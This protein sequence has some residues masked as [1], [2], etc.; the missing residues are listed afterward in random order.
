[1]SEV[2]TSRNSFNTALDNDSELIKTV[3]GWDEFPSE[4]V[5]PNGSS[6]N[7][8]NYSLT[9]GDALVTAGGIKISEPNNL[10]FTTPDFL[11]TEDTITFEF[12]VPVLAFGVSF[13]TFA[14]EEGDYLATNDLGE[15]VPSF[16]DPSFTGASTGA[17]VGFT[18]ED[19]FT[20]VT[21]DAVAFARYGLDDLTI[22]IAPVVGSNLPETL[23]GSPFNDRIS[24]LD[25]KDTIN[26][27]DGDDTILGGGGN[28]SLDGSFGDDSLDGANG[29]DTLLGG[30][31]NDTLLG[32]IGNDF[33]NS[34]FGDDFLEGGDGRDTLLGGEGNDV[35]DGGIDS[36]SLDG[37][38][39]DDQLLGLDGRDTLLG[40]I[41]ND[42]LD[43]GAG[44]DFLRGDHGDDQLFGSAENDTLLGAN[45][46]DTLDGGFGIDS[47][48]GGAG[49]DR[50]YG[51][52]G[53]D[54]L[55][56][57]SGNDFIDG[58]L[59]RD[60]LR[61]DD[62]D[63]TF[64][65]ASGAGTDLIVDFGRGN[66]LLGLSSGISFADLS[67]SGNRIV[68]G[69]EILATLNGIDANSLTESDFVDV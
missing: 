55:L 16:F 2:F 46:N 41:G 15:V 34:S 57:G 65:L 59:G 48:D 52:D 45:G 32:G 18:S 19:A 66:N 64:V 54:S 21:I 23:T 42:T 1:M 33:L 26:G 68:F 8:I 37:G 56:G 53:N 60:Y 51:L 5:I 44:V 3:E 7:G 27:L 4:S 10:F 63:D 50:L 17:F 6:V 20:S 62:G 49:S 22:A 61:G 25:G 36:D 40:G 67:F 35:L 29:F 43:G 14:T 11:P 38:A 12:A 47:L 31:G 69:D 39:G 9:T 13:N 24:G 28:D 58:G 30:E